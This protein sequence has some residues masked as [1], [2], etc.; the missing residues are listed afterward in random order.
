AL[1]SLGK[2]LNIFNFYPET[3]TQNEHTSNKF[4]IISIFSYGPIFILGMLGMYTFRRHWKELSI[5][6]WYFISFML[7][8]SFTISKIRFRLPLDVYLIIFSSYF[9]V[10]IIERTFAKF[11]GNDQNPMLRYISETLI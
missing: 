5:F 10:L 6:L 11:F 4:K 3:A 9:I 8:C 7:L 1:L 2:A